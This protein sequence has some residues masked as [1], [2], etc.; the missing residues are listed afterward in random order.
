MKNLSIKF[1][2]FALMTTLLISNSYANCEDS[3]K[4]RIKKLKSSRVIAGPNTLSGNAF[5]VTSGFTAGLALIPWGVGYGIDKGH[6]YYVTKKLRKVST[7]LKE[8]NIGGGDKLKACSKMTGLNVQETA[9]RIQKGNQARIFCAGQDLYDFK[10][11][12]KFV[13]DF[14]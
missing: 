9:A 11:I 13:K 1:L 5:V 2:G 4:S 6:R 10:A 3:Y 7:L 8:S 12:C 14:Q